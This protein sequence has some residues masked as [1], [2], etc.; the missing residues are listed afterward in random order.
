[1]S[2]P[3]CFRGSVHEGQPRGEVTHA[4]GLDAYVV[5]PADGRPVTGVVVILPD[6]F[7]WEFVNVRLLADKYADQGGFK[8]YAPDFMNGRPAPLYVLESMKVVAS[9]AG[10]LSKAYHLVRALCG[11]VP[12]LIYNWPTR[13]WPK[14]KGFFE[15]LRKEEGSSLPVGA[16]GFCWGGKQVVLLGRGDT[17]DGRP[18]ID[19]GFTGHPSLLSL[20]G[21]VEKLTLPVSFAVADHDQYLSIAQA[22]SIR[23]VVG[24]KPESARGE[25]TIYPQT[26]HG[27]CVRAD[28]HF[29]ESVKQADDATEQCVS[30]FHAHFASAS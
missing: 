19:A 30:W 20:P 23:A 7:G 15:Q 4:Y 25:V 13:A 18:L 27:F 17:I 5:G 8:V 12:F 2:C 16:A 26:G 14:V 9:S 28:P 10:I 11:A 21:D 29:P 1:M 3:D 22:E 6:A 24:A